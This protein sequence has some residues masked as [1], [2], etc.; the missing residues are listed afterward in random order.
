MDERE[1][2]QDAA[3]AGRAAPS[4]IGPVVGTLVAVVIGLGL[5]LL[6]SSDVATVWGRSALVLC[7]ALAFAVNWC[8]FVPSWL[9]RTERFYD[10]VGSS[11]YLI[12][13]GAAVVWAPH[14]DVVTWTLA[15][16]VAI[17]AVR[18]GSF[19]FLRVLEVGSDARFDTIKRSFPALL[20]TWTLQGLWVFV[21]AGAAVTAVVSERSRSVGPR[22]WI[23]AAMW[24]AGFGIEVVADRQKRA[25]RRS[26]TAEPFISTGLW[27]WSRHPNYFGEMTLWT[28]IAVMASEALTGRQLCALV[29]P[30][31]VFVLIRF[32]SGVP[33][34]EAKSRKRFGDLAAYQRYVANTPLLAL[35]PPRRGD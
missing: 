27:A 14:R 32:I 35:R 28:G 22:F 5:A 17:W 16:M 30:L 7:A 11:T 26:E 3:A 8:A 10:L 13:M 33:M 20:M 12:V 19:L 34:L 1:G 24:I 31:F 23:G 9:G 18:L 4:A 15:A 25:F 29:S 21:T 2:P 6:E